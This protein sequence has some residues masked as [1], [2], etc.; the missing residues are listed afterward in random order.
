MK[1]SALEAYKI[2]EITRKPIDAWDKLFDCIRKQAKDGFSSL[3][4]DE[5]QENVRFKETRKEAKRL[6]EENE[7]AHPNVIHRWKILANGYIPCGYVI[8]D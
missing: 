4:F 3:T 2:T 5:E 1:I 6:L 8:T 7:Y